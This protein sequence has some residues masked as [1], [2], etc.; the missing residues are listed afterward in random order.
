MRSAFLET[1]LPDLPS[2]GQSMI[3]CAAFVIV[4]MQT[5][6]RHAVQLRHLRGL[7]SSTEWEVVPLE[8]RILE[9]P[10]YGPL[11]GYTPPCYDSRTAHLQRN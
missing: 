3:M 11:L 7:S 1:L 4:I 5:A 6:T 2:P 9:I 10:G 8:N